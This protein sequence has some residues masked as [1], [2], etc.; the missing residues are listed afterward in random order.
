MLS[1]SARFIS[2]HHYLFIAPT[3]VSD[4]SEDTTTLIF[5][6]PPKRRYLFTKLHGFMY[7]KAVIFIDTAMGPLD[8]KQ[9]TFQLSPAAVTLPFT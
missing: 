8:T 9:V 5:E 7:L 6:M 3:D 1:L 4:V 2:L